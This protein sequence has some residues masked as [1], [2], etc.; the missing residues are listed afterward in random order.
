M[1]VSE[2]LIVDVGLG[3]GSGL[4]IPGL[5]SVGN[6]CSGIISFLSSV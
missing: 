3:V 2:I 4:A 1:I 6:M 5:A